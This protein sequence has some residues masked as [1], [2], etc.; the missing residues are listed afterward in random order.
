MTHLRSHILESEAYCPCGCGLVPSSESLD[1][2]NEF[3]EDCGFSIPISVLARCPEYNAK[4]GGVADS[5][6]ITVTT[7][8]GAGDYKQRNPK[9]RM[10]MIE[11]AI[12][13][14]LD[15]FINQ[16][17]CCDRHIHI[18]RV[19]PD[20]RLAGCFSWGQSL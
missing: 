1:W 2:M 10:K 14:F 15:G 8:Y 7:G 17:E 3:I 13:M 20:H 18:A 5:P 6:H 12:G 9:K 19:P 11:V 16:I 4:I